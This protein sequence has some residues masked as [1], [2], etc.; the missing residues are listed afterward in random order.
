MRYTNILRLKSRK[1]L[2]MK[3]NNVSDFCHDDSKNSKKIKIRSKDIKSIVE[4]Q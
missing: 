2:F 3:P 1:L 4:S